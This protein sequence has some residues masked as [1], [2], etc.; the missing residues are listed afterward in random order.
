MKF[1]ILVLNTVAEYSKSALCKYFGID[2]KKINTNKA[3]K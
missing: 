1:E 3:K 2:Q